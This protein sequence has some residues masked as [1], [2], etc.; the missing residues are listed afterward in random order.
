[1]AYTKQTWDTTS[2]VNPTRM[3]HIED[4]IKNCDDNMYKVTQTQ[5]QGN[6]NYPVLFAQSTDNTTKTEG[7][8]KSETLKLN[9]NS[10]YLTLSAPHTSTSTALD[11]LIVGND[12]PNGTEGSVGGVL[13]LFGKG[14][15]YGQIYDRQG[16]LTGNRSYELPD[17]SGV[18]ALTNVDQLLNQDNLSATATTY[19]CDWA[20]YSMLNITLGTY[21]NVCSQISIPTSE[22]ANSSSSRRVIIYHLPN[23]TSSYEIY[24]DDNTHV[25]I[26]G[27]SVDSTHRVKIYGYL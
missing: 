10:G 27:T 21:N 16:V 17:N 24:K 2:Y 7:V 25:Y 13:R 26:K 3:N 4:G 1:M 14:A 8:R 6:A 5:T 23:L 19:A 20:K 22:F 12:I 9:A 18:L 11:L 15:Y